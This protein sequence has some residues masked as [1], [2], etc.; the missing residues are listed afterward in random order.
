MTFVEYLQVLRGNGPCAQKRH[1][2]ALKVWLKGSFRDRL[3]R[4]PLIVCGRAPDAVSYRVG[5]LKFP[6][7][8]FTHL[9]AS[10][11]AIV[12]QPIDRETC[13]GAP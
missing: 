8:P 11:R 3:S 12:Y 7:I 6:I 2:V 10:I 4:V 1:A 13:V 5:A 9:R